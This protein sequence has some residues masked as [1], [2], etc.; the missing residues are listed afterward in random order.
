MH[1]AG[2]LSIPDNI[3]IMK[4]ERACEWGWWRATREGNRLLFSRCRCEYSHHWT[5]SIFHLCTRTHP[6]RLMESVEAAVLFS[7]KLGISHTFQLPS[8]NWMQH[9]FGQTSR[10]HKAST[11]QCKLVGRK[12]KG[13]SNKSASRLNTSQEHFISMFHMFI[14]SPDWTHWGC[15]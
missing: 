15:P 2:L 13:V 5:L 8:G 4:W 14:Y 10:W 9:C 11:Q 12:C 3:S 6:P 1:F 7:Q